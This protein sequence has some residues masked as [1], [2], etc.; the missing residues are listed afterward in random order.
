MTQSGRSQARGR[1]EPP[2]SNIALPGVVPV[3]LDVTDRAAVAAAADTARD[4]TLLINNAG[5]ARFGGLTDDGAL[6]ALRDHFETN[7]FG[8][9]S[10][11]RAFARN[12]A[13]NGGGAILNVLS[14][15]TDEFTRR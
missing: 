11:S 4:V 8:M 2:R 1:V 10:M 6:E 5:I 14:V 9:L 12:L 3:K 7:V 13:R 15:F